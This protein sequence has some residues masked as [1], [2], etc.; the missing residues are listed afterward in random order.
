[1]TD[2]GANQLFANVV[3]GRSIDDIQAASSALLSSFSAVLAATC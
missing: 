2:G 3:T 1:M